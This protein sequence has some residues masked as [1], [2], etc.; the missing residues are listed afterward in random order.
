[1]ID[2]MNWMIEEKIAKNSFNASA[3]VNGL[4]LFEVEGDEAKKARVRLYRDWRNAGEPSK[5]AFQH[6][7]KGDVIQALPIEGA[8]LSES[9]EENK[10]YITLK[11]GTLK[12]WKVTSDEGKAL[13]KKYEELGSSFSA[14]EQKDTPEQKEIICK[15]IDLVPGEIFLDWDGKYASK[16]EAKKYVMEYGAKQ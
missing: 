15:L 10:D 3:I 4:R 13:L 9:E 7:I 11:W 8:L 6:A 16:E 1:M 5:V 14:M 12:S 2:L